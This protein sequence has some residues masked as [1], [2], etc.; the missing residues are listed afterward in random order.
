M[1]LF[2]FHYNC[3]NSCFYRLS[4]HGLP[5]KWEVVH[6]FLKKVVI[7]A[8]INKKWFSNLVYEQSK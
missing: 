6:I 2:E 8:V 4:L 1:G 7:F 5:K 3:K